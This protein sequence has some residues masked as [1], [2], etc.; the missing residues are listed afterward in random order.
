MKYRICRREHSF[1][2]TWYVIQVKRLFRWRTLKLTFPTVSD[3]FHAIRDY[4]LYK[5]HSIN[6]KWLKETPV[7][8]INSYPLKFKYQ[9]S[10]WIDVK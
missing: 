3:A 8:I 2:N 6:D 1:C 7:Q 4:D 10:K 5:S 9:K